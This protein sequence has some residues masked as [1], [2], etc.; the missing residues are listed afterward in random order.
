MKRARI[1][2]FLA[3]RTLVFQLRAS[4]V[5]FFSTLAR[6]TSSPFPLEACHAGYG[7]TSYQGQ[8]ASQSKTD[9]ITSQ[10]RLRQEKPKADHKTLEN[11]M[12]LKRRES[13]R[14]S[15]V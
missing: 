13:K 14:V 8:V 5:R 6:F 15:E 3:P 7:H 10:G 1:G 2:P 11:L 4:H 9:V 12:E